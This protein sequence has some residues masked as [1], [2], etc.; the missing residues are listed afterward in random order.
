MSKDKVALLERIFSDLCRE[1]KRQRQ[2]W[3]EQNHAPE[4]WLVVLGEEVGEA[5]KAALEAHFQTHYPKAKWA[6]YRKELIEVAAVALSAV[7]S[8]DRN[9][10]PHS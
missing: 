2:L 5:N 7:E 8:L 3:G 10:E 9:G 1:L 6:D 4:W